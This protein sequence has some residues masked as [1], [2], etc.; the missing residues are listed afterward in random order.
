MSN[1]AFFDWVCITCPGQLTVIL[2][3]V[4]HSSVTDKELDCVVTISRIDIEARKGF[5]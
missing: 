2:L 4:L 3:Y 5:Q 1:G